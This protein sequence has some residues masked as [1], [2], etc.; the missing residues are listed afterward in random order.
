MELGPLLRQARGDQ[1]LTQAGLALRAGVSTSTI[2]SLES[3]RRRLCVD[4]VQ[5]VLAAMGWQLRVELEPAWAEI[6]AEID[7]AAARTLEERIGAWPV[8]LIAFV[9]W[10][11]DTPFALEGIVAAGL[12]GAPVPVPHIDVVVH[13]TDQ[14]MENLTHIFLWGLFA[15]RWDHERRRW[16]GLHPDPREPGE[17]RWQSP[18][19]GEFRIRFTDDV[20]PDLHVEVSGSQIPV[21]ALSR[22]EAAGGWTGRV[23]DRMRARVR[24][25]SVSN[26]GP[27]IDRAGFRR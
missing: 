13:D 11:G 1:G 6:D 21:V 16:G 8:D 22:V 3:G 24:Q 18:I 20:T 10:L 14:V 12:Q 5:R 9:E 17:L 7:A 4:T 15:N 19:A 2:S 26:E 25:E 27:T 23:L